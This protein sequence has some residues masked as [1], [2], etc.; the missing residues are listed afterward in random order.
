MQRYVWKSAERTISPE[1][2]KRIF[3]ARLRQR[4]HLRMAQGNPNTVG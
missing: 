1:E 4:D 2:F 3:G